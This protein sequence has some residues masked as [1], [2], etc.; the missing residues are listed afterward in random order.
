M[1]DFDGQ[2]RARGLTRAILDTFPVIKFS[3]TRPI[4]NNRADYFDNPAKFADVESRTTNDAPIE[5]PPRS[6]G[7]NES[8]TRGLSTGHNDTH[9]SEVLRSSPSGQDVLRDA[10][11]AEE[12]LRT[13]S[14]GAGPSSPT[15]L[16]AAA[17]PHEG[18]GSGSSSGSGSGPGNTVAAADQQ[19]AVA[20]AVPR[21]REQRAE[22]EHAPN[23]VP[24]AIGRDTC[25]ICIVDFE[26]GDDLRVLPC[27]GRHV[28]HQTCVDPW[29]LELSSSCP[30]CRHGASCFLKLSGF[31]FIN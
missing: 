21:Q 1:G 27:E 18:E 25:P 17:W 29:L 9:V 20:T 24:E 2:S 30:I 26:E 13:S 4:N 5:L 14:P 7:N 22:D 3:P 8:A 23:I 6:V 16:E 11:L 10:I 31:V 12:R 19:A 15:R 28:F